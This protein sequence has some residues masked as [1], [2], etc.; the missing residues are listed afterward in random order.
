MTVAPATDHRFTP[1]RLP[2]IDTLVPPRE[3][4]RH[5]GAVRAKLWPARRQFI[6]PPKPDWSTPRLVEVPGTDRDRVAAVLI[7]I[8]QLKPLTTTDI[9]QAVAAA[10]DVP[11]ADILGR[12]K[13]PEHCKPRMIAMTVARLKLRHRANGSL[14]QIGKFFDGRDHSTA[15]HAI[16]TYGALVESVA[17]SLTSEPTA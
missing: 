3:R 11:V 7:D 15:W 5:Y 12:S 9:V 14:P 13:F 6:T 2:A 8:E 17:A 1:C 10:F 16:N 4:A